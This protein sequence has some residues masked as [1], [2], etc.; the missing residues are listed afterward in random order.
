MFQFYVQAF[1][2]INLIRTCGSLSQ[3]VFSESYQLQ[4]NL[5]CNYNFPND[6][7]TNQLKN[8][9]LLPN[10]KLTNNCVDRIWHQMELRLVLNHSEKYNYKPSLV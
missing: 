3:P 4:P 1:W 7:A 8:V 6:F 2:P 10:T 5:D 9:D